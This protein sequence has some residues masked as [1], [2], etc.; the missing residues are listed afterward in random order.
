MVSVVRSN[1]LGPS[2][3]GAKNLRN[4]KPDI[5]EYRTSRLSAN[6]ITQLIH[7]KC[8]VI[9]SHF[10]FKEFLPG[11]QAQAIFFSS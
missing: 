1:N 7:V 4:M 3:A 6:K 10:F 9:T 11:K 8:L 5:T 2:I